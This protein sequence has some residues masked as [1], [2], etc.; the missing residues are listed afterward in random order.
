MIIGSM[1]WGRQSF[2]MASMVALGEL[3]PVDAFV[4]ADTTHERRATYDFAARWTPWLEEHGVR[5]VTVTA[6]DAV[7]VSRYGGVMIPAHIEGG[8]IFSRQC[9]NQWKRAVIRRWLQENRNGVQVEQW[10]GISLDEYQRMKQSDV[11]Y[12]TNRWP[13]IEKRMT[14]HDCELWLERH[15]LEIPTKS[16]CVFCPFQ[17]NAEWRQVRDN[18]D[19]WKAAVE[20]DN[21]IR[22]A[23]QPGDL[24]V[25]Q[26]AIPLVDVDL[27]TPEDFGQ[28][29]LWDNECAG[30]CG[31]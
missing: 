10:L 25:H 24:F 2:T 14:R 4:H 31:V 29:S 1:G 13:L 28:L 19:D 11:K 30:I 27:R 18:L 22:K 17:S 12:I 16:A 26:S 8:G 5:V 3:P 15:G 9:T 7:A 20:A 21:L 6:K 23:R